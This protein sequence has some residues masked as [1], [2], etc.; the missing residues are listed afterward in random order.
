MAGLA[1][2]RIQTY[3]MPL[4]LCNTMPLYI[5]LLVMYFCISLPANANNQDDIF[6]LSLEDLLNITV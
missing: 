2:L 4:A 5:L 3:K 1:Y 6:D